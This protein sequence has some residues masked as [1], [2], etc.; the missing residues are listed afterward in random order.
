MYLTGRQSAHLKLMP[1]KPQTDRETGKS[2]MPVVSVVSW[3]V[4]EEVCEPY[5]IKAVLATSG[6]VSRKKVLGQIAEFSIQPEDGRGRRQF[7]GFVSRFDLVSESR[8]GCTYCVVIRQRLAVLDGPS[9]C[10]TYQQKA[11]WEIIKSILER[12]EIRF[13]MQVE[14]RLRREHPK[15]DFR[16]QFN[17]GDWDY[18]R[19]EMEQA[20]LFCFTTTGKHGE[21]LVI[22]DDID[23]YERPPMVVPDRPTAGLSTFDEAI[24]SFRIRTRTVPESFAVADYNPESAWEVLRNESRVV[25]DDGTMVGTPY[26]WGT[27]HGDTAGAKREALLRHE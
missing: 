11:S 22:A 1:R 21:V 2:P 23:G 4:H 3:E 14:F 7:N 26:V 9:N 24:F 19:L 25:P 17:M 5:R 8:D 10:V 6:P 27:H 15:H 13:W 18:I 12:H 16:F 20:G